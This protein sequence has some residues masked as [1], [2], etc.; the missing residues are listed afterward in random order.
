[1]NFIVRYKRIYFK[2]N[3]VEHIEQNHY[4]HHPADIFMTMDTEF[5]RKDYVVEKLE[6]INVDRMSFG[7]LEKLKQI[8]I[9]R[10]GH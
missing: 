10:R 6:V 1:M 5:R 9:P 3:R 4:A 7:N 8:D 2:D